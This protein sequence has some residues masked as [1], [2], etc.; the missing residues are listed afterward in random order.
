[1]TGGTADGSALLLTGTVGSG[2]TTTAYAIADRLRELGIAHA[3]IDLDEIR[4][5]WPN[6]PDDPFGF[7]VTL[8]NLEAV[9]R[10]YRD[11]GATR[12]VLAGVCETGADRSRLATALRVPLTVVR[13][14]VSEPDLRRRLETRHATDPDARAWHLHRSGELDALLDAARVADHEL[15]VGD[16]TPAD[17]ATDVLATVDWP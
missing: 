4:R 11:A 13:L 1:M 5:C 12:L 15:E 8:R 14:R 9:A 10:T 7:A 3:V 6:P 16:R 17:L 2:K